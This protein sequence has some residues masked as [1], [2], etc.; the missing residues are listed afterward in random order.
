MHFWSHYLHN[1]KTVSDNQ[2]EK[3]KILVEQAK[4]F[5]ISDMWINFKL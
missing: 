5:W 1:D 2:I 3:K 4:D